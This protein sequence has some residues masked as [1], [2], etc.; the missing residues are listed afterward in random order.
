VRKTWQGAVAVGAVLMPG[1]VKLARVWWRRRM[2]VSRIINGSFSFAGEPRVF[3]IKNFER[4]QQAPSEVARRKK[5][6]P[7]PWIK[8]YYRLFLDPDFF[9][10]PA[11]SKLLYI[12]LLTL[13]NQS[14]GNVIRDDPQWIAHSLALENV[15]FEPLI[16][17]GFLVEQDP[18]CNL[19]ADCKHRW[20]GRRRA[21]G[22]RDERRRAGCAQ[23]FVPCRF[24]ADRKSRPLRYSAPS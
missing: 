19:Q 22:R 9:R 11:D 21:R 16:R 5:D 24:H 1:L 14:K 2:A 7:L 4:Y 15:D 6:V 3:I 13:A 23:G 12:G 10:L 18:A 17:T 8:L 20:R